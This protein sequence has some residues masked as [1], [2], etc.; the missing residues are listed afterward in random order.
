MPASQRAAAMLAFAAVARA[1]GIRAAAGSL[2]V[3]RSTASRQIA[4]LEDSLGGRLYRR[5]RRFALT[6]LGA[7]FLG[8]CTQL[9][10]LLRDAERVGAAADREPAGTLRI[11]ASPLVGE[12]LLPEIIAEYLRRHPRMRVDAQLSVDF[13]DLRRTDVDLAIR[14]GPLEDA[15]DLIALRLGTSAKSHYAAPEYLERRG[16]PTAPADL[17]A[18]DCIVVGGRAREAW[19]FPSPSGELRVSVNAALRVDSYRLARAACAAGV[20]VARLPQFFARPLVD[21]G[22]LVPLLDRYSPRATVFAVHTSGHPA[23]PK[24]R[25]FLDLLRTTLRAKLS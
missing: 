9:E 1:G 21:D 25:A 7:A 16:T 5:G 11:A 22:A 20:G 2:G 17:S 24:I 8:Q 18:H 6:D 12:E 14:T 3:P 4:E 10:E 13:V 15:S 19:S 23:P